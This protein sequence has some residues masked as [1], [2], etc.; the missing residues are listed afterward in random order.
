MSVHDIDD[1]QMENEE[2]V[3]FE[4]LAAPTLWED[5]RYTLKNP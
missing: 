4:R 2:E 1:G 5:V 3:S